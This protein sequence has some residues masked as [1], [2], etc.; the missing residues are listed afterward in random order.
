MENDLLKDMAELSKN[1]TTESSSRLR[2]QKECEEL[3]KQ[4]TELKKENEI[5]GNKLIIKKFLNSLT[6]DEKNLFLSV[7]SN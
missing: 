2:L 6:T 7:I 3:K 4:I 5:A 1:L